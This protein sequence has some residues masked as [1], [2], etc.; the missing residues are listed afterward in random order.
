[1]FFLNGQCP[2][3]VAMGGGVG[4]S[5]AGR[6]R[7]SASYKRGENAAFQGPLMAAQSWMRRWLVIRRY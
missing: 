1:L 7:G 2:I 4:C 3:M 5:G 6:G